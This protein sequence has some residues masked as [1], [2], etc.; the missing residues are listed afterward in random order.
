[1]TS[2]K[3][4]LTYATILLASLALS[5]CAP[6]FHKFKQVPKG[7]TG[8]TQHRVDASGNAIVDGKKLVIDTLLY[9]RKLNGGITAQV[10]GNRD[11]I[12]VPTFNKRVYFLRPQDGKEITSFAT[13]ASMETSAAV[14]DELV[15]FIESVGADRLTC[16]N[17]IN[18]KVVFTRKLRDS[19]TSPIL[20]GDD[21][22]VSERMGTLFNLNRFRGD[23][24]WVHRFDSQIYSEPAVDDEVV[25]IGTADGVLHCLERATGEIRWE[26]ATDGTIYAQPLIEDRVYCG[27]ADGK[28][29]VFDRN[30]GS[31]VW[32][33][34][35]AGPIHTTPAL[36]GDQ[37]IFGSDDRNIYCLNSRD[38]G[39]LWTYDT[40]AIVQASPVIAGKSVVVANSGGVIAQLDLEGNL[41]WQHEV[42]GSIK[43][44]P[45]V[46]DGI[47]FVTTTS[48]KLFAFGPRSRIP[49]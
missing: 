4:T 11:F 7:T 27:S 48:R 43:S 13:D 17:L 35:A 31:V 33:F 40:E 24:T 34:E 15:Y 5:A 10:V 41:L 26:I 49:S 21:L 39:M 14:K 12:V 47:V 6:S 8:F 36:A 18:G 32:Y 2:L 38:G 25:V 37:L 23:T 19:E 22:F 20:A 30:D 46:I 16:L 9:E 1:M 44:S 28:L 45:A 3:L 29:Y 42:K